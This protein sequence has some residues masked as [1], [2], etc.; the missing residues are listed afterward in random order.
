MADTL[1]AAL[2]YAAHGWPVFVLSRSKVPVRL[3]GSDECGRHRGD[4]VLSEQCS[5]L[6]CHGFY[7]AARDQ[8]RIKEMIRR[9]PDG[10]L[11]VRTGAPSGLVVIDVDIERWVD[12]FWPHR[13]D[14]AFRTLTQLDEANVL[15][16]TLTSISGSGGLHML[17]RHPGGYIKSGA[18][19]LGPKVDV[20]ADGGYFIVAPSVHPRT[21]RPYRWSGN[22]RWDYD[23]LPPL[24]PALA[25]RLRPP[26]APSQRPADVVFTRPATLRG[27]LG[28]LLT[29]ILETPPN[30]KR[31]DMLWWASRKA[32]EMIAAG[33][34]DERTAVAALQEAGL[35]SGLTVSEIGDA[36]R[37]TIGSG[38][39][40]G[41]VVA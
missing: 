37:G 18:A 25:A 15:P 27:R 40:K 32:A 12:D 11:A 21:G 17:Y 31:N 33:Q 35:A 7:A 26:V 2:A 16:G 14:V 6:T 4:P 13:E 8:G 38:L 1:D 20:K 3:C 29:A 10:C 22:G 9:H 28:G 24:H 23:E 39:R 5:C 19:L 36:T 30:T 34:L 41:R